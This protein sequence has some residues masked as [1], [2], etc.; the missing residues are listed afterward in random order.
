[1]KSRQFLLEFVKYINSFRPI[2]RKCWLVMQMFEAEFK[3]S[4]I[5][6]SSFLLIPIIKCSKSV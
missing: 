5:F 4:A 3:P 2:K 1:M 6:F